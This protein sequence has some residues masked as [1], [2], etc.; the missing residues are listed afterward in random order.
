[1]L[2]GDRLK[3]L[4]YTHNVTQVEMAEWCDVSERFVGMVEH[5]E[6]K[7]SQ[8]VYEAWINCCY[9]IGKPLA[10]REN[11]KGVKKTNTPTKK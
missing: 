11:K 9:G 4:R 5:N 6:C 2:S 10:K 3:F 7:P 8:E 1:M